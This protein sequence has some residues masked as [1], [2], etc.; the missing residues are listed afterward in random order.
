MVDIM[1]SSFTNRA[2]KMNL[3]VVYSNT[4]KKPSVNEL[5]LVSI[6]IKGQG[7]H[8]MPCSFYFKLTISKSCCCKYLIISGNASSVA[9]DS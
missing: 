3:F 2:G 6:L 9:F 4:V 5:R 1:N 7:N 8:Y